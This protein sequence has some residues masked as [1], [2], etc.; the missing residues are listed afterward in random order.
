MKN[1]LF[2]ES[3]EIFWPSE[4]KQHGWYTSSVSTRRKL[5]SRT[6]WLVLPHFPNCWI[7]ALKTTSLC[8]RRI[9]YRFPQIVTRQIKAL[10]QRNRREKNS[11]VEW[12]HECRERTY[13]KFLSDIACKQWKIYLSEIEPIYRVIEP[14]YRHTKDISESL[15]LQ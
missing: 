3:H 13:L 11:T 10:I 6:L 5:L 9:Y 8:E 15:S 7:P 4:V 14:I 12:C 2:G 1:N